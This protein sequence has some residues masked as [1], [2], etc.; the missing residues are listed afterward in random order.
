LEINFY[1]SAGSIF[2]AQ[3]AMPIPKQN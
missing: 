3:N 1:G 2:G